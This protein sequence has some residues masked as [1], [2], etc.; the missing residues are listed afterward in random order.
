M[1]V[2]RVRAVVLLSCS[3]GFGRSEQGGCKRYARQEI[4]R[5]RRLGARRKRIGRQE[6]R[7]AS[8][9]VVYGYVGCR[10]VVWQASMS[11]LQLGPLSLS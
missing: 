9:R 4:N 5:R 3:R 11:Q 10:L 8:K 2:S 6:R 1:V 7:L